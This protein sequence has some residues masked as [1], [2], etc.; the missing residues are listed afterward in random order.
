MIR[1]LYRQCIALAALF[2]IGAVLCAGAYFLYYRPTWM[3]PEVLVRAPAFLR[4]PATPLERLRQT[5]LDGHELIVSGFKA[6]D[7]AVVLMLIISVGA[8][9]ILGY[10]ALRLRTA[11]QR[12]SEN[13]L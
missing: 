2:L 4:D 1:S 13:A 6:L 12:G 5:A 8:A 3:T 10:V 9:F 7:V 11:L